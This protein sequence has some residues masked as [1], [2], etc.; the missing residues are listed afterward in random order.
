[1][2]AIRKIR[3]AS[4]SH[5][6]V[7]TAQP[8]CLAQWVERTFAGI[9]LWPFGKAHDVFVGRSLIG[10]AKQFAFQSWDGKGMN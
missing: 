8:P 2:N 10:D 1:L 7:T 6:T 9:D 5:L 3:P 4:A